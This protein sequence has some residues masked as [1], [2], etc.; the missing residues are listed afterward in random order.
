MAGNVLSKLF[1]HNNW[2]NLK[3]IQACSALTDKQLDAEPNSTTKGSIRL[4][5]RH[6][7]D[8]Q[9]RYL[10]TLTGAEPRFQWEAAPPFPE[11]MEAS[12]ISGE[13]VLALAS[14][15]AGKLPK[16]QVKTR[17]GYLVEP[18]VLMLQILNHAGEHREQIS[19]MLT[20][21]RVTPPALDGWAYGE[22][23][24]ALFPPAT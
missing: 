13:A 4:T 18:W 1:E 15:E 24:K 2:A 5:L 11:L 22:A 10:R 17:D 7:V 8:A 3:I 19:S 12:R 21:L 20:S 16:T 23:M 6:L 9:Q 14:D